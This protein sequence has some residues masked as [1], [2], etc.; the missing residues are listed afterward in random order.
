MSWS[1][2]RTGARVSGSGVTEGGVSGERK[3]LPL[4]LRSH[5]LIHKSDISQE[6]SYDAFAGFKRSY[7]YSLSVRQVWPPVAFSL[8]E[9]KRERES[10]NDW[11]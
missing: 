1:G 8:R 3:F 10:G 9:R 4:L 6:I 7:V 11:L 2:L 5:A